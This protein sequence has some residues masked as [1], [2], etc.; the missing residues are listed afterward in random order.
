MC[1]SCSTLGSRVEEARI[2]TWPLWRRRPSWMHHASPRSPVA[3]ASR[4]TRS[5]GEPAISSCKS[6]KRRNDG[7][8]LEIA[9]RIGAVVSKVSP[10][11]RESVRHRV[12]PTQAVLNPKIKAKK[13]AGPLV[14]WYRG[15]ALIQHK[16]QRSGPCARRSGDPTSMIANVARSAPIQ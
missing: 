1:T 4:S 8:G 16:F 12:E 14:V 3:V 5:L 9:A 15:E 13:F 6:S 2:N 10:S 7:L 11:R